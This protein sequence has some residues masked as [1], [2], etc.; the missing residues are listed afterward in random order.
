M[1]EDF[2]EKIGKWLILD[3]QKSAGDEEVIEGIGCWHP[4]FPARI[5]DIQ[6]LVGAAI[7]FFE[8][9]IM[10]GKEAKLTVISKNYDQNGSFTG[11]NISDE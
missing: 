5:D 4:L 11:L 2:N 9:E 3:S 7:K 6:M 1:V 8:K 10:E